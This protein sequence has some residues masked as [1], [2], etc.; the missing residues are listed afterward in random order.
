MAVAERTREIGTLRA[1]GTYP[2]ELVRNFVLE[3]L[4]IGGGG[5][6]AGMALAGAITVAL[7]FAGLQMPPPPGRSGGYPLLVNF[8]APL[9]LAVGIAVVAVSA[10]AAYL[11]SRKA[12]AKPI[13]EALAH[14]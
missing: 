6:L 2:G 9:Y 7:I 14:V 4:A 11:A 1:I 8:S 3:G 10:F 12:V 13:T 5:A